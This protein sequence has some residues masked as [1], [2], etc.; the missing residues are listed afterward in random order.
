MTRNVV[1]QIVSHDLCIG[2]G[3]CA[4]ICPADAIEMQFN[5]MGLY[6][7][8]LLENRCVEKCDLCLRVCPFNDSIENEEALSKKIFARNIGI[9]HHPETGHFL[10]CY[11]GFSNRFE[12]RVNGA[13]GGLATWF[14]QRLIEED[15]AD[16]VTSVVATRNQPQK[17]F[18]FDILDTPDSIQQ[19]S[20]SCYYPVELSDAIH[21][22]LTTEGRY[23]VT[24][25]PCFVKALRLAMENNRKLKHRITALVGLVCGHTKS[26]FFVEYLAALGGI[27][28]KKVT[29]VKFREKNINRSSNDY[30]IKLIWQ[31]NDQEKETTLFGTDGISRAWAHDY[32]KPSPCYFCDDIFAETADIVFMDAWLPQYTPDHR[33]HSLVINRQESFKSI[34][35]MA[36][37][38][39]ETNIEPVDIETVIRSQQGVLSTKRE[40]LQFRLLLARKAGKKMLCKRVLPANSGNIILRRLWRLKQ[41]L[42]SLTYSVW[43]EEQNLH[44]FEQSTQGIEQEISF[45]EKLH[46]FQLMVEE[47][48]LGTALQKRAMRFCKKIWNIK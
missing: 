33:G 8:V 42:S 21:R 10:D 38:T 46:R 25:L 40:G 18:K 13:S 17:L 36:L 4:G 12:Q 41:E 14:L 47:N 29:A 7:P 43:R 48:R 44:R 37:G 28:P 20:R 11:L 19:A 15:M 6:T 3:V 30:G 26:K 45:L 16:R 27:D 1:H 39:S 9:G 2:C 5:N 32:F 34:W 31:E 35:E 22:I 24:G 23:A